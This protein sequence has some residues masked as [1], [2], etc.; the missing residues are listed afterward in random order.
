MIAVVI[1]FMIPL[2]TNAF[3]FQDEITYYGITPSGNVVPCQSWLSDKPLG[4]ILT[5]KWKKIWNDPVC[6]KIRNIS[7]KADQTCQ[8]RNKE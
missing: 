3:N 1:L 7:A 2:K 6:E 8:L 4:N 5:D